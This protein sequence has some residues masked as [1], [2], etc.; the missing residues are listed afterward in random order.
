MSFLLLCHPLEVLLGKQ[1]H[2]VPNFRDP[3]ESQLHLQITEGR[4]ETTRGELT[5]RETD[6]VSA[7]GWGEEGTRDPGKLKFAD[8]QEC[9][10]L[11]TSCLTPGSRSQKTGCVNIWGHMRQEPGHSAWREPSLLRQDRGGR[12]LGLSHEGAR[13]GL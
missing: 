13:L 6:G 2:S 11:T 10:H 1:I 7:G 5:R 4:V 3:K 9:F 8:L 12:R